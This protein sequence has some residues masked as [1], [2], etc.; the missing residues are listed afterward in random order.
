MQTLL[1]T[2]PAIALVEVI[3]PS[4]ESPHNDSVCG[5]AMWSIPRRLRLRN[6]NWN[7]KCCGQQNM[8]NND[9]NSRIYDNDF[10]ANL[11]TSRI[12]FQRLRIADSVRS[13]GSRRIK[14]IANAIRRTPERLPDGDNE[15]S[16]RDGTGH[17]L[18]HLSDGN[19]L[20][21]ASIGSIDELHQSGKLAG[22][23][24]I[25]RS[26]GLER[27]K[28]MATPVNFVSLRQQ[29][30]AMVYGFQSTP[31]RELMRDFGDP[32]PGLHLVSLV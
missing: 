22:Y 10:W 16:L 21:V 27:L 23:G 26:N 32:S 8:G 29:N 3:Y 2:I 12:Q 11:Y 14:S 19:L 9:Y 24:L 28:W 15:E 4:A 31:M 25:V 20:F 6:R 13:D 1:G 18:Y 7:R 30:P 5:R 17:L